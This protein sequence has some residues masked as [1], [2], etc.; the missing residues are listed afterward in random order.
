[1][2]LFLKSAIYVVLACMAIAAL[3]LVPMLLGFL[4]ASSFALMGLGWDAAMDLF[5][6]GW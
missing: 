5:G 3:A 6:L 4:I 2:E 1:M